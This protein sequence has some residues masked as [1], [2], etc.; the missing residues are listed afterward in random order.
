[1][2]CFQL[3]INLDFKIIIDFFFLI[4]QVTSGQSDRETTTV[5]CDNAV[6]TVAALKMFHSQI[7]Y[8]NESLSRQTL[9][10]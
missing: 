7:L 5:E 3:V 1:M 6:V 2:Y 4:Y 9:L 8:K 10:D